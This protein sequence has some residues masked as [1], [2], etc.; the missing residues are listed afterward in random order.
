MSDR[1]SPEGIEEVAGGGV[2]FRSQ[3]N[4]SPKG[5]PE[6]L[7][8]HRRGVWDLPKGK[9][10][11]D[12]TIEECARREVAE[13]VGCSLPAIVGELINTY[14]TFERGGQTFDKTTHW[15]AMQIPER[16]QDQ[17]TPQ[18]E[19]QI[20]EVAWVH[21]NEAK[22]RVAFENLKKLLLHFHRWYDSQ[23]FLENIS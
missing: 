2:L 5:E 3:D 8:I 14:H 16:E 1:K 17:L 22:Q 18:A 23:K 10:E 19:E 21:L 4:S 12:E 9:L 6:V 11:D 15:F 20:D 13:E 7:L